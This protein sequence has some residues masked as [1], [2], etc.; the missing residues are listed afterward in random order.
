MESQ[1]I[2]EASRHCLGDTRRQDFEGLVDLFQSEKFQFLPPFG[3]Q[4]KF[5]LKRKIYS[6]IVII[7]IQES[8]EGARSVKLFFNTLKPILILIL[9]LHST[10]PKKFWLSVIHGS[11][12]LPCLD[13]CKLLEVLCKAEHFE[14]TLFLWVFTWSLM[15]SFADWYEP[16]S[17]SMDPGYR[18]VTGAQD[19]YSSWRPCA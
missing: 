3:F 14:R 7:Q 15:I 4:I 12:F 9:Q 19:I 2:D 5:P 6:F 10:A 13:S 11:P 1:G 17:G 8:G 16:C 18:Q